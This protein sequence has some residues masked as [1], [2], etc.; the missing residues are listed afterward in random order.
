M[1]R[2]HF[3]DIPKLIVAIILILIL[4]PSVQ[5]QL[6]GEV[7]APAG[8]AT[9][10]PTQA[11]AA[12]SQPDPAAATA[13]SEEPT[14]PT[15]ESSSITG[16]DAIKAE[17][18]ADLPAPSPPDAPVIAPT[19][20]LPSADLFTGSVT[21][22]GTGEPGTEIEITL[23]GESF[24][25]TTVDEAGLWSATGIIDRAGSYEV[26][27]NA[28][29]QNG[30]VVATS[31]SV[32]IPVVGLEL[33][34][35]PPTFDAPVAELAP[36]DLTLTGTGQPNS[37]V[38]IM[39]DDDVIGTATVDANGFWS[40]RGRLDEAGD[41]QV[42][43]NALDSEGNIVRSSEPAPLSI[44]GAE[45]AAPVLI[46]PQAGDSLVAG[47]Q[48]FRGTGEPGTALEFIVDGE[49]IGTTTVRDNGAW[50]FSESID[51]AGE[52]ELVVNTLDETGEVIA[53]GEAVPLVITAPEVE[54][55]DDEQEVDETGF[56]CQEEYTVVA[57]DW[58]S[59]LSDKYYS[60]L[61]LYPAIVTATNAKHA[62]DDTFAEIEDPDVIE[63]GW[64]LCIVEAEV[65]ESLAEGEA[66]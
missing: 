37:T 33:D 12:A 43:V 47:S 25:R 62:V 61:F 65:A 29:D 8:A 64:R 36:G 53:T 1:S 44:A 40:W 41:Y 24:V 28:L 32:T 18:P 22:L 2:F 49:S 52:I 50:S 39:V 48:T 55:V 59:K 20:D 5:A 15:D 27:V 4:L 38:E 3:N 34:I 42:V 26:T 30:R 9:S 57:D 45:A 31:E 11:T 63:P 14:Q 54:T 13:G 17:P 21:L 6:S 10:L 46:S 23:D 35:I 58:L 51:D 16:V 60:D 66:E 7:D 19:I 56:T